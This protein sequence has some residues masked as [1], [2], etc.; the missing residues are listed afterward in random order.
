MIP[1]EFVFQEDG[2]K[3]FYNNK[4][5]PSVSEVCRFT[6]REYYYNSFLPEEVIEQAAIRGTSI[7]KACELIDVSAD[8]RM[9]N[10]ADLIDKGI[11]EVENYGYI[12]A[13]VKFLQDYRVEWKFIE[14]KIYHKRLEYAGTL[15]R[16]GAVG[17]EFSILDIKSSSQIKKPLLEAQLGGYYELCNQPDVGIDEIKRLYCLH[18]RSNGKYTLY[19]MEINTELFRCN[20]FIHNRFMR[21]KPNKGEII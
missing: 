14:H 7:H 6:N 16:I 2:H 5:V 13:Y 12:E 4:Q 17:G 10:L 18:L 3:Y 20:L 15:D 8:F 21:H 9:F 11:I 1:N 19:N